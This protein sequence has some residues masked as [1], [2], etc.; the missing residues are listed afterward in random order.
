LTTAGT[1]AA[2]ALSAAITA[3]GVL[4]VLI[5]N[6]TK[7]LQ[8]GGQNGLG[9]LLTPANLRRAP[10]RIAES[11]S[12]TEGL[13]KVGNFHVILNLLACRLGAQLTTP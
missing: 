3:D 2:R 7:T 5:L 10:E 4:I 13:S 6:Q 9:R 1:G 8:E 11:A 12:A